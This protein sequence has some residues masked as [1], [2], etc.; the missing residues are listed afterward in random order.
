MR[1]DRLTLHHFRNLHGLDLRPAPGINLVAGPNGHGKSNLLES[2]HFLCLAHSPRTR[3]DKDIIAW[4]EEAFVIRGEGILGD[5]PHTQSVEY[6]EGGCRVKLGPGAGVS[7]S[8]RLGDLLGHF[9][10]VAFTPED[11]D[12]LRGSPQERRR[13]LDVLQCQHDPTGLEILRRYRQALRQ[14]NAALRLSLRPE[15]EDLLSAY[16]ATLAQAGVKIALS[17]LNL[18][19]KLAPLAGEFYRV[20]GEGAEAL[21][22]QMTRSLG[23]TEDPVLLKENFLQKLREK[24]FQDREN[25]L[26]SVGPHRDD[27]LAFLG[28]KSVRDFASQGQKR[29][30]ALALKLA[31]S[32]LLEEASGMPPILLLDDVFAEL[33]AGRRERFGALIAGR[34]QVF[35]ATPR[36]EDLPFAVDQIFNLEHGQAV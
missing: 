35:I 31:S 25:G 17:R 9:L 6:R 36:R 21:N 13:F 28:E 27:L 18:V 24:R 3:K 7:E 10:L 15:E 29:S 12:I 1:I 5:R 20:I 19:R 2:L 33:D 14:R 4:G 26:T 34:S 16:E 22:L 32:R 23:P 11:L 8:R 30:V